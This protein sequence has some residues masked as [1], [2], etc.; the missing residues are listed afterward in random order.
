MYGEIRTID[1]ASHIPAGEVFASLIGFV[2]LYSVLF[3][4]TLY[5]GRRIILEGPNLE[6]PLPSDNIVILDTEPAELKP[7]QRPAEAQQ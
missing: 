2:S 3:V 1:A 7:N 4:T 6:L 5:F